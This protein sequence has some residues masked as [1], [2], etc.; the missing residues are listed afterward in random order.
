[1]AQAKHVMYGQ[2]KA[3]EA[4][5]QVVY[6][7]EQ[8]YRFA[9]P[10]VVLDFEHAAAQLVDGTAGDTTLHSYADGLEMTLYPIV[11]QAIDKPAASTSGMDYTYD[12][13]DNDGIELRMSD[14]TVKGRE[15]VDRFTVGKQAFEAELTFSI[16]D[17]SGTD[18]CA[19]GFA[20]VEAHQAAID[21]RD[22]MAVL[23]VISGD[24]KIETILNG[25]STSTTDTTDNFADGETHALK[26][27]V[28]KDGA[29]TYQI[30][31][32]APSTT[33]TFSFDIGEVVTPSFFLLQASDLAGAIVF[34][35][36]VVKSDKGSLESAEDL[37]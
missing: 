13:T 4:L 3:G 14:S 17:V 36:L 27:K 32:A 11:G 7:N 16:A 31:G 37:D 18:D 5:S 29:V 15:G 24:I 1:M 30:N 23:N 6:D 21:D 2:E 26:V 10:P 12:Q 20:K 22:E 25:G 9:T 19:F 33:A 35:K 8:I 28:A 34:Q